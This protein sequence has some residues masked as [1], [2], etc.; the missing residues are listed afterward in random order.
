MFVLGWL[1]WPS[2]VFFS[3][4]IL[5]TYKLFVVVVIFV[6]YE[7]CRGVGYCYCVCMCVYVC[8]YVLVRLIVVS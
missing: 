4:S 5:C 2:R 6:L 7:R 1:F 8:V 3:K